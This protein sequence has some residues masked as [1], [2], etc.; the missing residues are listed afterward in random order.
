MPL[1]LP[2]IH[3][4]FDLARLLASSLACPL[5]R[6]LARAPARPPGS[7]LVPLACCPAV[8]LFWP[9]RP[10]ARRLAGSPAHSRNH[11]AR[12]GLSGPVSK[13]ATCLATIRTPFPS[14]GNYLSHF[15]SHTSRP[16]HPGPLGHKS[17]EF[18]LE[19]VCECVCVCKGALWLSAPLS[20]TQEISCEI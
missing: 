2:L 18:F 9:R 12:V 15:I 20:V 3:A 5:S 6:S 11:S 7:L 14:P 10:R 13:P 1:R 4:D 16:G 8:M 17:N 19:K